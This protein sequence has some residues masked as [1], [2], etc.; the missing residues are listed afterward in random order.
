MG[1]ADTEQVV[2]MIRTDD[3]VEAEAGRS[4][5]RFHD[6]GT[7]EY[8]GRDEEDVHPRLDILRELQAGMSVRDALGNIDEAR[9]VLLQLADLLAELGDK[10]ANDS[11][12]TTP[13]R[14]KS[15]APKK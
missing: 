6:D 7:T 12:S 5:M 13:A 2:V 8:L 10:A 9:H 1:S 11:T 4:S 3:P 14:S 15:K